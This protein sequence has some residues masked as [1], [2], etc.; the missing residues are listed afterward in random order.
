MCGRDGG[1]P[2][3]RSCLLGRV[4]LGLSQWLEGSGEERDLGGKAARETER[5]ARQSWETGGHTETANERHR[6]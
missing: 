2:T 4:T 5:E 3:P 6:S 1:Q